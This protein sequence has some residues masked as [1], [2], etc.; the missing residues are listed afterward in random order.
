MKFINSNA[1]FQKNQMSHEG[2]TFAKSLQ[3]D[4][5]EYRCTRPKNSNDENR[6]KMTKFDKKRAS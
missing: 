6:N 3:L 4:S 5:A 1:P 2:D